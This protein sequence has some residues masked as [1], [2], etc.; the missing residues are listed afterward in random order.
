MRI[1]HILLIAAALSVS[2]GQGVNGAMPSEGAVERDLLQ[3]TEAISRAAEVQDRATLDRLLA[4][5]FV[6]TL[7]DGRTLSKAEIIARWTKTDPEVAQQA[8]RI[9]EARVYLHGDTAIVTALVTD[10]WREKS[11]ARSYRERIFD[12]WQ[13]SGT[14][15][16][17]IASKPT[18]AD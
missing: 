15:W 6:M 7:A 18:K 4:D 12:V 9:E 14:S 1:P 16:R 17:M 13:K 10:S 2:G 5:A 11:V 8:H 3:L